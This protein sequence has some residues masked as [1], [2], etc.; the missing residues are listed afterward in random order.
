MRTGADHPAQAIGDCAQ[1]VIA[2]IVLERSYHNHG[3]QGISSQL[4]LNGHDRLPGNCHYDA[5]IADPDGQ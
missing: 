4:D 3:A 1:E 5:F 2:F